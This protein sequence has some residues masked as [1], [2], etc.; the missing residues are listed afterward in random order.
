MSSKWKIT[1]WVFLKKNVKLRWI[2][3][4]YQYIYKWRRSGVFD[5]TLYR[6]R[7]NPNTICRHTSVSRLVQVM[8]C[9]LTARTENYRVWHYRH[10]RCII[11]RTTYFRFLEKYYFVFWVIGLFFLASSDK[12]AG[13]FCLIRT[14]FNPSWI[15]YYIHYKVRDEIIY[16]FPNFNDAAVAT[17]KG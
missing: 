15:S 12:T 7:M 17:W 11:S 13:A 8:A 9:C 6:S 5:V 14:D 16:P 3:I 10:H 1:H 4:L 2:I